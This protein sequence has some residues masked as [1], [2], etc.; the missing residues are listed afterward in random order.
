MSLRWA[1]RGASTVLLAVLK[2]L[3]LARS[4][5]TVSVWSVLSACAFLHQLFTPSQPVAFLPWTS[6]HMQTSQGLTG[7]QCG[8]AG[9]KAHHFPG[10]SEEERTPGVWYNP[11]SRKQNSRTENITTLQ[12]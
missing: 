3:W 6:S 5:L 7:G 4:F 1:L 10:R 11:D 12:L 8:L 2:G 9:D